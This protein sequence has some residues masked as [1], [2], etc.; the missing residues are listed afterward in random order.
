MLILDIYVNVR[1]ENFWMEP[2]SYPILLG[3]LRPSQ[4]QPLL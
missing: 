2:H 3:A 1:M 4:R